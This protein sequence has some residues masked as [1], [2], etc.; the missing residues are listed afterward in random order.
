MSSK[1]QAL[2]ISYFRLSLIEFLNESHP[3]RFQDNCFII[4]RTDAA[5]ET[6]EQAIRN[7][8]TETCGRTSLQY[9]R[10]CLKTT[11]PCCKCHSRIA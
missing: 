2:D 9:N 3:E 6:Y 11:P 10:A 5:I 8:D 7:G 1:K 4:S